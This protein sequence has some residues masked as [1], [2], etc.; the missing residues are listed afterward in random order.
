VQDL[1]AHVFGHLLDLHEQLPGGLSDPL[2]DLDLAELG[3]S[4]VLL[5]VFFF[6]EIFI[7]YDTY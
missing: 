6:S 3:N 4:V 1:E 2:V 5:F 7:R